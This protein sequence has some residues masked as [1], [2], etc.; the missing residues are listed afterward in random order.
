MNPETKP[1]RPER[2]PA[3]SGTAWTAHRRGANP[4]RAG[5]KRAEFTEIPGARLYIGRM[6]T[7]TIDLSDATRADRANFDPRTISAGNG[8]DVSG[9]A[10]MIGT[11]GDKKLFCRLPRPLRL[12]LLAS[13]ACAEGSPVD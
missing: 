11:N 5:V 4:P 3:A 10:Q 12:A 8:L 1:Q 6:N 13:L 9:R 2:R 7:E